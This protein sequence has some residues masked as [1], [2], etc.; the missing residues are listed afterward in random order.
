MTTN[1]DNPFEDQKE[2]GSP[3]S[4]A[5]K[6]AL[7]ITAFQIVTQI[8]SHLLMGDGE[9]KTANWIIS[10]LGF[11]AILGALLYFIVLHRDQNCHG[12]ITYGSAF[13]SAMIC[14]VIFSALTTLITYIWY[15][16]DPSVLEAIAKKTRE[17]IEKNSQNLDEDKIEMQMQMAAKFQTPLFISIA[18]FF[19]N[20]IMGCIIALIASAFNGSFRKKIIQ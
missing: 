17:A 5:M 12:Q 10:V 2:V 14:V 9:M 4:L 7:A 18:S 1:L 16:I 6:F 11:A 8:I 3:I 20:L 13:K 15:T 19:G